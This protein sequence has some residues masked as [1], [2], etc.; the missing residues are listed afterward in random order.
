MR[1]VRGFGIYYVSG[2]LCHTEKLEVVGE[3]IV[4]AHLSPN[5]HGLRQQGLE[6]WGAGPGLVSCTSQHL[7]VFLLPTLRPTGDGAGSLAEPG[8]FVHE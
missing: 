1:P 8:L 7:L 5:L 6:R 2:N 3:G 4:P